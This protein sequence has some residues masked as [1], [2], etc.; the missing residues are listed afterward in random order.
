MPLRPLVAAKANTAENIIRIG[1]IVEYEQHGAPI[2]AIVVAER[3][4]KWSLLNE[5]GGE[6][7]LAVNRLYLLPQDSLDASTSSDE[8]L[9]YLTTLS[10]EAQ[11]R[12]AEFDLE[13]VWETL[14]GE[15]KE[16]TV[17]EVVEMS[18]GKATAMETLVVRRV[19][20][21]DPIYFKRRKTGFEP[22]TPEVVEEL[23]RRLEV[24]REKKLK[25]E[26]FVQACLNRLKDES[27]ELP[28]ELG[29]LEQIAA[30]GKSAPE[31]SEW[32]E[33]ID[34]I[35]TSAR[36]PISGKIEDKAFEILVS[37]KH[38][39]PDSNIMPIRLNR[40]LTFSEESLAHAEQLNSAP[41]LTLEEDRVDLRELQLI[42]IDG[43]ESRDF[44]DALS[45]EKIPDGYRIGIHISDVAAMIEPGTPLDS[46]AFRRGTSVYLPDQTIP[47]FPKSA[48]E[49]LLSLIEGCERKCISFFVETDSS[50]AFGR[51][52]V[53]RTM[54][55]IHKRFTYEEADS[56]LC[57]PCD[58]PEGSLEESLMLLWSA[59]AQ[60]EGDRIARDALQLNRRE[61]NPVV[62]ED[63]SVR[64]EEGTD[65]Q[66]ARKLVSEMMIL[67][68]ETA[69]LFAAE[70]SIPLIFRGQDAPEVDIEEFV[71]AIPEGPAREFHKRSVLKRSTISCSPLPHF[72]LGVRAYVHATS[73]IRRAVDLINHRQLSGFLTK[74]EFPYTE[75]QITLLLSEIEPGLDEAFQMQ[76]SRNR[77]W[78]LKYLQQE[79]LKTINAVLIKVDGPRPLAELDILFSLQPFH[80]I[81]KYS[82]TGSKYLG[83]ELLLRIDA[84]DPRKEYL[85]LREIEHEK[86]S[87]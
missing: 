4:N 28:T 79:G 22:R 76:R 66:P 44:D 12:C 80:P 16:T 65:D 36:L 14:Q 33:V 5:H 47:M 54:V 58:Y 23:K 26:R 63:G 34:E 62:Q 38:F 50:F 43:S 29:V 85:V 18:F 46:E 37:L 73:P 39:T 6:L 86:S 77:Y 10:Q 49:G 15:V 7:E 72:G 83:K 30:H 56:I 27:V 41:K 19:L 20:L 21:T 75:E 60:S 59:S 45:I 74:G 67:A 42:T 71:K 81:E 17:Q 3:K 13:E 2:L 51:R 61:M 1:S 53:Q 64:L 82:D 57:E 31:A 35:I 9:K 55:K 69:A 24:E 48:S 84:I 11:S 52:F 8:K 40:P 32:R 68:N 87:A 25:R 78:L 70:H